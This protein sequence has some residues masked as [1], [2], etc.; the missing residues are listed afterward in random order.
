[1]VLP[2]AVGLAEHE[3]DVE[4]TVELEPQLAQGVPVTLLVVLLAEID[5]I[6]RRSNRNCKFRNPRCSRGAGP[7]GSMSTGPWPWVVLPVEDVWSISLER[8]WITGSTLAKPL[9]ILGHCSD[10]TTH[11]MMLPSQIS[12]GPGIKHECE[13]ETAQHYSTAPITRWTQYGLRLQ[14]VISSP[15]D[16][17]ILARLVVVTSTNT[18]NFKLSSSNFETLAR[19]EIQ[20]GHFWKRR[21]LK[22]GKWIQL[23]E[24]AVDA[25]IAQ[26]ALSAPSAAYTALQRYSHSHTGM[27]YVEQ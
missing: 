14:I 15:L 23:S 19:S 26:S 12:A 5:E 9:F 21:I 3:V 17:H 8:V 4:A 22:P 10:C 24:P 20:T 7:W 18:N 25:T 1:M 11:A 6:G 27:S 13:L 2:L 16:N